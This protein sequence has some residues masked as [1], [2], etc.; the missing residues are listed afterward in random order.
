LRVQGTLHVDQQDDQLPDLQQQRARRGELHW[1][2]QARRGNGARDVTVKPKLQGNRKFRS[3]TQRT[4]L[5]TIDLC[6]AHEG[7]F[8]LPRGN[9]TKDGSFLLPFLCRYQPILQ[10]FSSRQIAS[11]SFSPDEIFPPSCD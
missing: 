7:C 9:H 4:F 3:S 5:R 6:F 11:E 8:L 2:Q 1:Q 10:P